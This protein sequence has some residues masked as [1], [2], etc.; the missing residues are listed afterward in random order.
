[1]HQAEKPKL[2]DIVKAEAGYMQSA[3]SIASLGGSIM[4]GVVVCYI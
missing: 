4:K 1:M 3:K 2:E